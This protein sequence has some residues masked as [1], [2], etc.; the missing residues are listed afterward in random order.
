MGLRHLAMQA[1][2]RAHTIHIL[3]L[4]QACGPVSWV[5]CVL[6]SSSRIVGFSISG[7]IE[8]SL[9]C[10]QETSRACQ[11]AVAG[12]LFFWTNPTWQEPPP[13]PDTRD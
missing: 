11:E 2:A 7:A 10:I 3:L 6:T 13:C 9:R 5:E 8:A 12:L 4:S 1:A